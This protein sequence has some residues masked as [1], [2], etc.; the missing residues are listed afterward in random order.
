M[1]T[2]LTFI[3]V[4]AT[5][6]ASLAQNVDPNSN[7]IPNYGYLDSLPQSSLQLFAHTPGLILKKESIDLG[8]VKNIGFK[9]VEVTD[10]INNQARTALF[11]YI[12]S[13]T[14]GVYARSKAYLDSDEIPGLL[15]A[16]S[17]VM[18]FV[19]VKTVPTNDV[20]YY[21][22][23]RGGVKLVLKNPAAQGLFQSKRKWNISMGNF[24]EQSYLSV[25]DLTKLKTFLETAKA[26]L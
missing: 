19:A 26:K 10:V 21:Y 17:H 15:N 4:F 25:D 20:E 24:R 13:S 8:Y 6:L 11:V 18:K 12:S 22:I 23:S 9:R 2:L 7:P 3:I 1:K 5:A 14:P 16:I